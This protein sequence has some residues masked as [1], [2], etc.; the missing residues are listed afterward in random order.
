M[1]QAGVLGRSQELSLYLD[2][3]F[4]KSVDILSL[5]IFENLFLN[6]SQINENTYTVSAA[7]M[8][9]VV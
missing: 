8:I 1:D 2:W 6:L 4:D 7:C 3:N 5:W 9:P